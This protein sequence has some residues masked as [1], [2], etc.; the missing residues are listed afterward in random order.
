VDVDEPRRDDESACI[1]LEAPSV[2]Q[3]APDRD[4]TTAVDRNVRVDTGASASVD[5]MTAAENDVV[6]RAT[7]EEERGSCEDCGGSSRSRKHEVAARRHATQA[8]SIMVARSNGN[9]ARRSA[10]RAAIRILSSSRVSRDDRPDEP[11]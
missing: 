7:G 9:A 6:A 8:I 3:I 1:E 4:Q 10:R 11:F 2:S 5:D